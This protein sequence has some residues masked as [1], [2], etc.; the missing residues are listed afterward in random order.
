MN[1]ALPKAGGRWQ[2]PLTFA[3][4]LLFCLVAPQVPGQQTG[5]FTHTPESSSIYFDSA[6]QTI[7]EETPVP[8]TEDTES[9][10]LNEIDDV[11]N[12]DL[13]SLSNASV[14]K[15]STMS[16]PVVEGVSKKAESLSES[17]G[18][19]DVITAEDIE[20]FGAKNLYEVLQ[21]ATS[22][23]M[24][25]SFMLQ[26]NV[27]S[28]RGNLQSHEDNHV[29]LLINGRPYRDITLGGVNV[30]LYTAFPIHT[31]KHI[32]VIRGPGSVLYGTNAFN[33]AINIVTKN[34][35]EPTLHVATLAGSDSW[36]SYS[37]AG[38]NGN[39]DSG[40]YTGATYSRQRGWPFTATEDL[41]APAP[42]D[43][44]TVPWGEDNFGLF[45]MYR[46]GNFT[47]NLFVADATQETLGPLGSLPPGRLHDPRLFC[48]LGYLLEVDEYQS[49]QT[50]F[51][52]NYSGLSFPSALATANDDSAP[53]V[54]PSHSFLLEA[55]YQAI[56]TDDLDFMLGGFT[57]FHVGQAFI[58]PL[59]IPSIPAFTEIWYGVYMQLEYQATEWLKLVG[60]MQA[61]LPGE[62]KS[63]IV[64]R[65]G[66][67]TT[68]NE[69]WTGKFLYGQAFRSPYAAERSIDVPGVLFGN[70]NLIPETIQTFDAQLA[71]RTDDF[72]FAATY[73]HSDY[74]DIVT[75]VGFPQTYV[76]LGMM[77]FDGIELENDWTITDRLRVLGSTTYQENVRD[78]VENTTSVPNWMA[79][80]GVAYYNRGLTLGL[81]DTF[82]GDQIVPA[83]AIP[84]NANP[85]AYHLMSL[86]TTLDLDKRL[87]W[88]TNRKMQVQFMIQ[89]LLDEEIHHVEFERE[90]I[91]SLP[92]GAGRTYYGGLT[93]AY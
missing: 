33:G 28:I 91:N 87:N 31:I 59:G 81:F 14:H 13:D 10:E 80:M 42:L 20:Q 49:I 11:L 86:N 63:G 6:W 66:A 52:Y 56:L 8:P 71:Y 17:P 82:F 12:M 36:Q 88:R 64:P 5:T 29:L 35:T 7:A 21:R 38:G 83:T 75:R 78:G 69:H 44:A 25:G 26:R 4:W 54:P 15:E 32:E 70:P 39:Q 73:F 3:A 55:T 16:D 62:I 65:F 84:L 23:F 50:N 58:E 92:A 68:L 93:F 19:V 46:H 77:E 48:D 72:R 79:K 51:T 18:I 9:G 24:T 40:G 53:F 45:T 2:T 74:F 22:V 89:N 90:L 27:A 61:N 47:A 37:L 34:P 57:D 30:A 60:G 43:T 85:D 41:T 1:C 67:I 76:N